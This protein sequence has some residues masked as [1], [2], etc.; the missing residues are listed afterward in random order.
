MIKFFAGALIGAAAIYGGSKFFKE[1]Q[2]QSKPAEWHTE[3]V[4][5]VTF[6]SPF[7]LAPEKFT[8]EIPPHVQAMV[9]S[10]DQFKAVDSGEVKLY[11][12]KTIYVDGV[13][14]SIAGAAQGSISAMAREIGDK[15]PIPRF[16]PIQ[17]KPY[18]GFI[19]IYNA[20]INDKKMSIRG[21]YFGK[22]Q[23]LY[24]II[25]M[26]SE[27]DFAEADA[28]RLIDSISYL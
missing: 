23:T 6:T 11:A 13:D 27:K 3:T 2:A 24:M 16:E 7:K 17:G 1:V 9:K 18:E 25:I 15:T 10:I 20:T 26:Y 5:E 8:S 4:G 28:F 22:E 19:G 14:M 21:A 12:V